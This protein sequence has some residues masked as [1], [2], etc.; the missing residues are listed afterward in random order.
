MLTDSLIDGLREAGKRG[1]EI[2]LGTNSPSSTDQ[3]FFL[4]DCSKLLATIPNLN[5]FV[6][7]GERKLHAKVAVIDDTGEVAAV[8][9]SEK[10]AADSTSAILRDD[11]DPRNG[12]VQYEILRNAQGEPC[13]NDGP[14][15]E[16]VNLPEVAYGP[17]NHL[18]REMLDSYKSKRARWSFLRKHVPQLA[19][20][21]TL[22]IRGRG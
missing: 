12:V 6:A 20:L 11:A 21:E 15:G 9:W 7:K 2:W 10:F 19:S 13:R 14:Q 1:V 5:F 17:E 18:T 3:A 4:E 16:L 22:K 8:V